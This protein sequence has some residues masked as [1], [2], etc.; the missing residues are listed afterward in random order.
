[1]RTET[2]RQRYNFCLAVRQLVSK[3]EINELTSAHQ[4]VFV[5]GIAVY[6]DGRDDDGVKLLPISH[7]KT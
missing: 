5:L 2:R 4:H 6:P 3:R 1:M 7:S